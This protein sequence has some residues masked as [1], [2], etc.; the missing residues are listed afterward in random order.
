M[1]NHGGSYLLNGV[2]TLLNQR[3]VFNT[4][5]KDH[6]LSF[7]KE[8]I[9]LGHYHDCRVGEILEDIGEKL[10]ICYNCIE[11]ADSLTDSGWCVKCEESYRST[12]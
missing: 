11:F 6:T 2:I 8:V 10:G 12:H 1:S 7:I 5:G 4:I 9:D 3:D